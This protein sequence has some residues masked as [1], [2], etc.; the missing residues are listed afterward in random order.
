MLMSPILLDFHSDDSLDAQGVDI[1]RSV[2]SGLVF[3][4]S[5]TYEFEGLGGD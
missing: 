5:F 1:A 4:Y 2:C 3:V